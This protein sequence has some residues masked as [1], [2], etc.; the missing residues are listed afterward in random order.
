MEFD[1]WK[2]GW[3]TLQKLADKIDKTKLVG[4]IDVMGFE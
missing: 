4:K 3:D 2:D 1:N